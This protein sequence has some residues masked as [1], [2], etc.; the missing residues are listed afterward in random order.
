MTRKILLCAMAVLFL[1]SFWPATFTV[2]Q[3]VAPLN[4]SGLVKLGDKIRYGSYSI[5]KIGEGIYQ[6]NDNEG[7]QPDGIL[8]ALG[9][10]MYLICG[11]NK[12]LMIDLG[13]NY[14]S[15]YAGDKL[16]PRAKSFAPWCTGWQAKGRLNL[17]LR[18]CIR[19][20]MA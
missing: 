18:T 7:H 15:G 4:A 3:N 6:I 20:M 16:R 14:I 8:G 10:D 17:Q 9:V 12:A 13:N 2:A 1:C 19:I 11:D 5:Y